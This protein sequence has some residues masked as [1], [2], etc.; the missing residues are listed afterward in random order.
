MDILSKENLKQLV[1]IAL[2]LIVGLTLAW[3]LYAFFP[4]LLGA[5]TLYIL[6]REYYFK[7][8]D[9]RGWKKWVAATTFIIG[10]IL[11]FVLPIVLLFQVLFPKFN[12]LLSKTGQL[13]QVLDTLAQKLKEFDIPLSINPEQIMNLVQN[14]S[15]SIPSFLGATANLL[16]NGVLAFFLL[17][18]MLIDG[19]KM[20]QKLQQYI[21]LREQNIDDIWQATRVMVTSNAIGIPTLAASQAL[22]AIIGYWIFGVD[23]YVMW[24]VITGIFSVVPILGC[25]IVWLPLCIYLFAMGNDGAA[26]GL[27]I[28]SFVITGGVDNVL[29]FTILK[30]LGDIHPVTTTLG[31][32]VGVPIFG[33]MGFIF[34]PLLISYLILLIRVYRVE[35]SDKPIKLNRNTRSKPKP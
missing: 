19:K 29:R 27:A 22:A 3:N 25:M 21:P 2:I 17:Y 33:F 28:Y 23:S 31:I 13:T 11:L 1:L 10:S 24:G 12:N 4:G 30:K 15:S 18:F 14:V 35:F 6:M 5:I 8:T 20:E 9:E 16:T 7:L 32:I 26:I 34:G